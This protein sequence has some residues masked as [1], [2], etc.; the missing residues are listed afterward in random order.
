MNHFGQY[1][2]KNSVGGAQLRAMS[3]STAVTN[4]GMQ[5]EYYPF[6]IRSFTASTGGWAPFV[7]LGGQYSFYTP[8]VET[9]YGDGRLLNQA[10]IFPK[11]WV[12]SEGKD[13][14]FSNDKG[15]TW[16]LVSSV[17]TRYKLT[18]LSDLIVDLRWQYYFDNWVDG[19]NPNPTLY[20][21]NKSNDWLVWLNFGY[22]YYLD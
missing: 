8:K 17:G 2:D 15:S 5:L 6:S 16:T 22:I 10:N 3:G 11:Y 20:P 21:E 14:G 9:S 13:H 18:P 7:S 19:L 4:I 12:A 1:A